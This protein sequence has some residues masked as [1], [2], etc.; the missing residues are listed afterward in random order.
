MDRNQVKT[1]ARGSRH[2]GIRMLQAAALALVV[3]MALPSRAA[4][5][6]AI[7]SRVAPVYPEIAKRMKIGGA[8]KVEATVDPEGKVTE[9][10]AVSGNRM[11]SPAAE[12][13]VR[14][15]KF[16]PGAGESMVAVEINFSLGQ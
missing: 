11:L 10:K 4:D 5:D 3:A 13:A 16:A 14:K 12:D 6:R 9:A 8:V 7:K 2:V 1:S 15:W